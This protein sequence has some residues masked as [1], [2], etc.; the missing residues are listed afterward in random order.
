MINF[1]HIF[2]DIIENKVDY[3]DIT[4][5]K[6]LHL[7]QNHEKSL[8][9]Y[10]KNYYEKLREFYSDTTIDRLFFTVKQKT[11]NL[12]LLAKKTPAFTDIRYKEST[13][14]SIFDRTTSLLL[15]ENYFLLVIKTYIDLS[16][17]IEMTITEEN[18][19]KHATNLDNYLDSDSLSIQNIGNLKD[20]KK[21]VAKILSVFLS[22][23]DQHKTIVNL[24]YEKT[25]DIVFKVNEK[26][27]DVYFR[28]RLESL[29]DD[30]KD[31]E[32]ILKINKLGVWSKGLQK[33]LT[34]YV[35]ETYDDEREMSEMLSG[36]ESSILRK[37]RDVTDE[38]AGIYL[39]DALD[40]IDETE[41]IDQEVYDI[42]Q[43]PGENNDDDDGAYDDYADNYYND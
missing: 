38:T 15:F 18:S 42:S 13:H 32:K 1:T 35:A 28:D 23:M 37:N 24:S 34:K 41:E 3:E 30:E 25:Q 7:S 27:K 10:V 6:Y 31:A 8:K 2:P 22:I 33:G 20:L 9:G 29:T 14:H 16:N 26:E 17:D 40:E 11:Q 12:L 39:S 43:F 4:I 36:L 21:T 5:Q 19:N